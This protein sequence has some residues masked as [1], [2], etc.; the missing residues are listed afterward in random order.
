M[1]KSSSKSRKV[2]RAFKLRGVTSDE[3]RS[4]VEGFSGGARKAMEKSAEQDGD[5]GV[6]TI[7]GSGDFSP[8]CESEMSSYKW[9]EELQQTNR[10]KWTD[11]QALEQVC[12]RGGAWG[13]YD[14]GYL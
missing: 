6:T 10:I 3:R 1:T 12:S 8:I 13:V 4:R 9:F 2:V 14:G 5:E 11:L 7:A